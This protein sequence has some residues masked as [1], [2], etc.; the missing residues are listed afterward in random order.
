MNLNREQQTVYNWLKDKDLPVFAD[1]YKGAIFLLEYEPAGYI[2]FVSHA[3]RDI[4]NSLARTV[5]G[6]TTKQVQYKDLVEPI[7]L[8]W[9]DRWRSETILQQ[10]NGT[11]ALL[12]PVKLCNMI[13]ILVDEHQSGMLRNSAAI[14]L[15]FTTFLDYSDK[16]KIPSNFLEEWRST[17]DWFQRHTHLRT[18]TF[19]EQAQDDL[20]KHFKCLHSYLHIAA[21]SHYERIKELN[22][23]L[24]STN[25]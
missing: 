9:D 10:N 7:C 15:F 23:I 8:N 18:G 11:D 13:T 6:I 21:S 3:G 17:K 16:D 14:E 19:T 2:S 12:I 25:R 1:A 5:A 4:M 20:I 22:E 24:D